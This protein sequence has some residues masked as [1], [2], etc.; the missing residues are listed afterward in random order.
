VSGLKSAGGQTVLGERLKIRWQDLSIQDDFG[1][2]PA[3]H[4]GAQICAPF[5][6]ELSCFLSFYEVLLASAAPEQEQPPVENLIYAP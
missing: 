4:K 2:F 5:E 6:R 3:L 1:H